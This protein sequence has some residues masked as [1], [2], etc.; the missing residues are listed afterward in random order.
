MQEKHNRNKPKRRING[1]LNKQFPTKNTKKSI[2]DKKK[3]AFLKT[4]R[5]RYTTMWYEAA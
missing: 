5:Y 1:L 2:F 3:V 4:P